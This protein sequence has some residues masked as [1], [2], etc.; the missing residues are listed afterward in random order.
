MPSDPLTVFQTTYAKGVAA[1][2]TTGAAQLAAQIAMQSALDQQ[3]SR[4]AT[5]ATPFQLV[6]SGRVTDPGPTMPAKKNR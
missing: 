6:Q 5:I 1:G 4:S 2:L 3:N